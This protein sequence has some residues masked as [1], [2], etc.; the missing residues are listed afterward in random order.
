MD[1][2]R[3]EM[4]YGFCASDGRQHVSADHIGDF[5]ECITLQR[6]LTTARFTEHVRRD[7]RQNAGTRAQHKTSRERATEVHG[8]RHI[9]RR[10][11]L[12]RRQLVLRKEKRQL[13]KSRRCRLL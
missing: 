2:R 10:L 3:I 11:F 1:A 6:C 5:A 9:K 4:K 12:L 7:C 13:L 8:H